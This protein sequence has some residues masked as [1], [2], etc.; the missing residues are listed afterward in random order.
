M[1]DI[2]TESQYVYLIQ[3]REFIKTQEPI[4]KI[5]MTKRTPSERLAGYPKCTKIIYFFEVTNC[6][7]MEQF[8]IKKFDENF[9]Q[10]DDI[11]REYYEGD[12]NVMKYIFRSTVHEHD[13]VD[14]KIENET[15][16]EKGKEIIK[17]IKEKYKKIKQEKEILKIEI[18]T[19]KLKE[20]EE[21]LEKEK[22]KL[23]KKIEESN[24]DKTLD[25]RNFFAEYMEHSTNK[26]DRIQSSLLYDVY[27][28]WRKEKNRKSISPVYFSNM[29]I[30]EKI[31]KTK[32]SNTYY[33]NIKF[34]ESV[35]KK[36]EDEN[37]L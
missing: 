20:E 6:L 18:E 24:P 3:E 26:K 21:K 14:K 7:R 4:Y 10:C 29:M 37:F 23:G 27:M 33:I 36:L 25:F 15:S 2:N 32:I 31:K 28:S 35:L 17:E 5:G 19:L 30:N 13:T 12:I 1:G 11:G 9:H 8:L 16:E 22:R 34:K